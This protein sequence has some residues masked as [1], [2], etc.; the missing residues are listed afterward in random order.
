[1][2]DGLS[3][4]DLETS[5]VADLTLAFEDW[6]KERATF[7][8]YAAQAADGARDV[9]VARVDGEVAG[10]VTVYWQPSYPLFAAARIPEIR[11]FN[12]LPRFQRRGVGTALMDAAEWRVADA[13][14]PA[15]GIGVGLYGGEGYGYGA[16]QRMYVKRGY[17][18]DGAGMVIDG[19]RVEPGANVCLDDSPVLMFTKNLG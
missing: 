18:P 10:Y 5:D 7:E 12:V 16:A 9:L 15:V 17:V 19:A 13:G 14:R 11:D 2:T 4:A 3:I 6:P 1:V 8:G